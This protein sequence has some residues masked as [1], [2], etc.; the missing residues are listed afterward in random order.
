MFGMVQ[1]INF[2]EVL[3]PENFRHDGSGPEDIDFISAHVSVCTREFNFS[4]GVE[5]KSPGVSAYSNWRM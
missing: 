1:K 3:H 4:T 2:F 5:R